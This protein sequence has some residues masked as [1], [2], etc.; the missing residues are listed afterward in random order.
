MSDEF[1]CGTTTGTG[2]A[3]NIE[4]GWLPDLVHIMNFTDGDVIDIWQ[5][6]MADGTG[7]KID[8]ATSSRASGGISSYAGDATHKKGFTIGATVSES[9]D[10]LYWS[11]W[12]NTP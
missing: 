10:V 7:I 9:A 12:R 5:R 11:A 1:R 3:I 4:L 6:G 2:A 8:T